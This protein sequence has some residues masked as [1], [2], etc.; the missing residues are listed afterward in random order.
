MKS[1]IH[2][3]TVSLILL[4]ETSVCIHYE[5]NGENYHNLTVYNHITKKKHFFTD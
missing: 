3:F 2:D 4:S 1:L 5:K